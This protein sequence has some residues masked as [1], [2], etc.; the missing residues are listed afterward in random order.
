MKM[1][2]SGINAL[3]LNLIDKMPAGLVFDSYYILQQLT[4]EHS[5]EISA[6][7]SAFAHDREAMGRMEIERLLKKWEPEILKEI[8][9]KVH[10]PTLA[11]SLASHK[12]WKKN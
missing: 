2:S 8:N 10:F 1:S 3:L 5:E 7:L 4:D 11:D 6:F 12:I 9:M